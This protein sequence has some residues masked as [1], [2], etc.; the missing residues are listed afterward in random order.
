MSG[1]MTI[2]GIPDSRSWKDLYNIA[3]QESDPA[4]LLRVL[5]DAIN[6]VLDHIVDPLPAGEL[7]ELNKALN[8]LRSRRKQA[9]P[10]DGGQPHSPSQNQAA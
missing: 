4:R 9:R 5:D 10:S 1:P 6:S 2:E 7:E 3:L 8:M